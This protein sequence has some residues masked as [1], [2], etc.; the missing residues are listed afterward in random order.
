M[1]MPSMIWE[2]LAL[3]LPAGS[4]M[5]SPTLTSLPDAVLIFE[6]IFGLIVYEAFII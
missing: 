1:V 5:V 3:S 6:L 4:K 2:S